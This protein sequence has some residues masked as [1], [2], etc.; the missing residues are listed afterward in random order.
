V[1]RLRAHIGP[2]WPY[3]VLVAIPTAA[4]V[5]PDLL[6]GHLLITGDNLQQNYPLH[7]L[8]GSM[9]RHGQLP[10]WNTY[11]FS[12]TPL[13]ADFNAGAF[14]PLMGLFVVLPDRAA[15]IAT[16]A[17]L[18][19]AIAVGMYVFLRALKL[20]TMACVVA[21]ATF[22]FAGPV[23]NQVNH[24]DMTEGYV[25]IPWM[26][27]AVLHI[28]RDGRWRW[29]IL[30]GVAFA[31]VIVA[32]APEA[33][34]DEAL[35]VLAFA[36]FSA[37]LSGQRWWRVVSRGAAGAA[38]ALSLAA[39]QWLPGLEAIRNSQRGGGVL[40][41]AGSYPTPFSILAL[42]PYLD[43]G[44]GNLGE[45]QFFS[46]Y[47]LPEVGIYLGVLPI[48]ALVTLW[49][50]RW[51]SRLVARDRYTWYGV[52]LVGYLLALGSSTPLE[53]LFNQLPLYGHQ[54]LQSRNM[55]T[56]AVALCV[57]LAAWIDRG[58]ARQATDRWRWF[59]RITALVPFGI[60]AGLWVWA[61]TATGSLVSVFAGVTAGPGIT[62]TVRQ[63][64]LIALALCAGAAALVWIRPFLGT[65]AWTRV[66]V[67][68][69][70]FDLALMGFTSQ[71][72]ATPPNDLVSG[73]TPIEQLVAAHLAPGAR[74]VNYDPQTYASYPG[75]P[76]GIPDLNII[77]KLPSISGY[78]SIVN[79]NYESVTHTHEQDDLDIAQ[80]ASGALDKLDLR[81]VVSVPEYFLV[82]LAADP[83]SFDDIMQ[84]SEGFGADPVLAR[85]YGADFN[86]TAYPFY[87]GPHGPVP[88]GHTASWFFGEPLRVA[89]ATVLFERPVG[90]ASSVRVGTLGAGG[91][92]RWGGVVSVPAGASRLSVPVPS[93]D[94]VGLSVR[95]LTGALSTSR[96]VI[97]T[98][99]TSYELGGSLSS[100]IVPGPWQVAGFS[101]GYAVFTLRRPAL[102]IAAVSANGRRVP[103]EVV[104]STTKSEQIRLDAPA[105]TRVTR[106]VAW[107]S[108]WK[109]TISVDGG[110]AIDIP[111]HDVDLVQEVQ[112]P[113]GHVVVTFHYRPPH[114]LVASVLS[115]GALVFL[116]VL[117]GLWSVRSR[118]RPVESRDLPEPETEALPE[119]PV[120]VG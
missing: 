64:T 76:Q 20:S 4:F 36:A 54:R 45:T 93:G 39:I 84:V 102:P 89:T 21:A 31:S 24:V 79:G 113:A 29:S 82:P 46:H 26:L 22:A 78:A 58:D 73:T 9:W 66:M 114:L 81:E 72:T 107:D 6:G 94:S 71:L 51:P 57:L 53:H 11:I 37:G 68:F 49:H 74:M 19:S 7:V 65:V 61:L 12:G 17:I 18:F 62:V 25:A 100:A 85:G 3:V 75:S 38:L 80:L 106:S 115:L 59:D 10:F 99:G 30:L 92:T 44:Y 110:A 32:G 83:P 101:Q 108:G 69:V 117:L 5:L 41:A 28:V 16:E 116:F 1:N 15:W 34:L 2:L 8:V 43:G 27:L 55:I 33:M 50:P 95:V 91:E 90:L 119:V 63:A 40:A 48:I 97:T 13:M 96:V 86:D 120:R 118:R 77:P 103:V 14:Y 111:V 104:S 42:V 47:N 60:V 35:L 105:A 23:L 70:A 67:L 87:P 98:G 88:A 52:A 109:A 112:V 56:V